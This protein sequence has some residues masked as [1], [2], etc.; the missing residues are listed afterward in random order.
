MTAEAIYSKGKMLIFDL[1]KLIEFEKNLVVGDGG[2]SW[3]K[4][5][6]IEKTKTATNF[7]LGEIF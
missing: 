7:R 2:D 6:L 5:P 1:Q 4:A 3:Y